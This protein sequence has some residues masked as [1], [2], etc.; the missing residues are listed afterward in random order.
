MSFFGLLAVVPQWVS[1]SFPIIRI[2]IMILLVILS[3]FMIFC[4]LIQPGN[5]EG[6]GAISGT[7]DT[8]FGKNKGK[9]LEG[10]M[11]R[12]T[13]LSAVLLVVLSIIF[14]ASMI[15]YKG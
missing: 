7:S 14:I 8:F 4:V 10:T 1:A 9:T 5:S 13:V 11:K 3:G 6:L 15:I 12:L 2:I